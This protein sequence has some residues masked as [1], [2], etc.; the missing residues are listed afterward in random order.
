MSN[1]QP[2]DKVRLITGSKTMAVHSVGDDGKV[3]VVW[4]DEDSHVASAHLDPVVLREYVEHERGGYRN[5]H[6]QSAPRHEDHHDTDSIEPFGGKSD[7]YGG[8]RRRGGR[9]H[10]R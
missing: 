6:R 1:F 9:G 3:E 7:V 10:R 2:G 8:G 5:D 4:F